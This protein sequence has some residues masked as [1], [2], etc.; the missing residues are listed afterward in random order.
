MRKSKQEKREPVDCGMIHADE[1]K[2]LRCH[3]ILISDDKSRVYGYPYRTKRDAEATLSFENLSGFHPE[4]RLNQ[5]QT[6]DEE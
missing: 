1:I 4:H 2:G 6:G 5:Y 3:W